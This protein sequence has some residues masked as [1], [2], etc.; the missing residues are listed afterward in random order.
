MPRSRQRR[1]LHR[2]LSPLIRKG[3]RSGDHAKGPCAFA[4]LGGDNRVSVTI[5][6]TGMW[7]LGDPSNKFYQA[8]KGALEAEWGREV[9]FVR[10]GGTMPVTYLLEKA[11]FCPALHFPLGQSTDSPHVANERIG[12]QNLFKGRSSLRRFLHSLA[13]ACPS[14]A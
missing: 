4:R 14:S 2:E 10:E 6:N 13:H 7:W 9:L 3:K 8:A 5:H 11:M 1:Q 12:R